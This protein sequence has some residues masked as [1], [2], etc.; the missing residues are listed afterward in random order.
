MSK[1][2]F[3]LI[4]LLTIIA[5]IYSQKEN[6]TNNK[7]KI[8]DEQGDNNF[9]DD[10]K[11]YKDYVNSFNYTNVKYYDDTNYTK[12]LDDPNPTFVLFYTQTCHYCFKFLPIFVET[13]DYCHEK[14]N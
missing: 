7:E 1:N 5:Y 9:E 14:K 10:E 12:I 6:E 13:A 3:I 11:E 8:N 2:I 4:L